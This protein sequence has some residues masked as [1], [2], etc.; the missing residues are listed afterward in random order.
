M[1]DDRD[2]LLRDLLCGLVVLVALLG[3]TLAPLR[4]WVVGVCV[5]VF[6]VAIVAVLAGYDERR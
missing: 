1:P 6:V 2:A 5:A 4:P 3:M